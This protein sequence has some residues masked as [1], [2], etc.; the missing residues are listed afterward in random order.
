[1]VITYGW[2]GKNKH[3]PQMVD[4]IMVVISQGIE[5]VKNHRPKPTKKNSGLCIQL[6]WIIPGLGYVVDNHGDRCCSLRIGGPGD[7]E[8]KWP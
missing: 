1:M 7:P 5:S 4:K 6:R 8:T 2:F 3:L